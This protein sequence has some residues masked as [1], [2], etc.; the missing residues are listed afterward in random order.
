MKKKLSLKI[1]VFVGVLIIAISAI[2]GIIAI[3]L[4]TDALMAQTS[5]SML[6]YAQ[7]SANHIDAEISKNLASLSEVA[8]RERTASMDFAVQQPS[9]T[10]DIKR[11]GY[12][13]MGV[14]WPNGSE[15]DLTTGETVDLSDRDYIKTAMSGKACTSGV[16]ISKVTGQPAVIKRRRS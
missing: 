10:A 13:S 15:R 8:M 12:E 4:S 2:L 3:K 9:L 1:A 6:Q 5:E 7:E 14:V 16:L 11:L